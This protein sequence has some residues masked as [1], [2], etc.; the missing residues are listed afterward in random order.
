[1]T[2]FEAIGCTF[3]RALAILMVLTAL[4]GCATS[5]APVQARPSAAQELLDRGL[6]LA[7]QGDDFAA[8]QYLSAALSAGH[9]HDRVARELVRVCVQGGRLERALSHAQ[10][11]VETHPDD[12]IFHHVLATIQFAKG[13]VASAQAELNLVLSEHP[14]HADSHFLRG[15]IL[16][17]ALSDVRGAR[18]ALER[19]LQLEPE[20]SHASEARAWVRRAAAQPTVKKGRSR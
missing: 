8:E 7:S 3:T 16:R 12:W 10:S 14:E 4:G 5:R 15:V 2:T 6:F 20:G 18:R 11:Y 9:P 1:M 17:D 19:Y 13:D